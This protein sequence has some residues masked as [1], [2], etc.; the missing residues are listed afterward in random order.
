MAHNIHAF[1][2]IFISGPEPYRLLL[3]KPQHVPPEEI[4]PRGKELPYNRAR[5]ILLVFSHASSHAAA[6]K[7]IAFWTHRFQ[8]VQAYHRGK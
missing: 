6:M 1:P 3:F 8:F 7:T 5:S 2:T 4:W